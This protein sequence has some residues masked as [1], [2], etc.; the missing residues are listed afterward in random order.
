MIST[1]FHLYLF[2]LVLGATLTEHTKKVHSVAFNQN[3][4]L[5]A[6]ASEDHTI[7]IWDTESWDTRPSKILQGHTD[8][9]TCV[10]FY[11]NDLLVS[12]SNDKTI[13][14]SINNSFNI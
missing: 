12:G 2:Y 9:V 4:L 3:G 14:I 6:S 11:K 13:R 10:A 7:T 1:F 5:L 8:A